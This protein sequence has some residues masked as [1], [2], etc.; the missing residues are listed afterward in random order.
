MIYENRAFGSTP[1]WNTSLT[2]IQKCYALLAIGVMAAVLLTALLPLLPHFAHLLLLGV[3]S[4]WASVIMYFKYA[5]APGE[6]AG[7][8]LHTQSKGLLGRLVAYPMKKMTQ[9]FP[10]T[11]LQLVGSYSTLAWVVVAAS[12]VMAWYFSLAGITPSAARYFG[13]TASVLALLGVYASLVRHIRFSHKWFLAVSLPFSVT[14]IAASI[15]A[16]RARRPE[17][18]AHYMSFALVAAWMLTLLSDLM[19]MRKGQNE[20]DR[21]VVTL[22]RPALLT[23]MQI[24][25]FTL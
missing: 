8:E 23:L 15:W 5:P 24:L 9:M 13:T 17:P 19:L 1:W 3:L 20:T 16:I 4:S 6:D 21:T 12:L 14:V 11:D 10:S 25:V 18:I 22:C 2:H 7:F